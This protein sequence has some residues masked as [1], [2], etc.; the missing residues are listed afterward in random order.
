MSADSIPL[1]NV[2]IPL[3]NMICLR[4]G[5]AVVTAVVVACRREQARG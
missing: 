1:N 3:N 5:T 4:M 2:S